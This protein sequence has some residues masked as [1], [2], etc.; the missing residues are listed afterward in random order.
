MHSLIFHRK[1]QHLTEPH[2]RIRELFSE[3]CSVR[4]LAR[5]NIVMESLWAVSGKIMTKLQIISY[6]RTSLPPQQ[7]P[8]T[9]TRFTSL[10]AS[11]NNMNVIV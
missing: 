1:Y 6:S 10:H 4:G 8:P 9:T 3:P 11:Y 5:T 2:L 7:L